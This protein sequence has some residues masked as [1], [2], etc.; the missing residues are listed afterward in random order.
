MEI[1]KELGLSSETWFC[2]NTCSKMV[3]VSGIFFKG[4]VLRFFLTDI[5]D[6]W[7]FPRWSAERVIQT[8]RNRGLKLIFLAPFWRWYE[9]IGRGTETS[10]PSGLAH[11]LTNEY[12][13]LSWEKWFCYF[14]CLRMRRIVP[15]LM[16]VTVLLSVWLNHLR[17]R[18]IHF[19]GP[20]GSPAV[21]P[22]I[23]SWRVS[24]NSEFFFKWFTSTSWNSHPVYRSIGQILRQFSSSSTNR[25][26][27]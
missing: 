11:P 12:P 23:T 14:C 17:L 13:W 15:G 10:G 5:P 22:V 21:S 2:W 19:L 26:K 18:R 7:V 9:S 24:S 27:V 16:A 1:R 8:R 3:S 4:L 6:D 20:H 25:V